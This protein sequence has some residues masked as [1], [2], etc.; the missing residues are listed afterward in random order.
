MFPCGVQLTRLY[1]MAMRP[2][3]SGATRP[4]DCAWTSNWLAWHSGQLRN[5][6]M[7]LSWQLCRS[8]ARR[9]TT[10]LSVICTVTDWLAESGLHLPL[11]SGPS[12]TQ[13]SW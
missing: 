9:R 10:H 13:D 11:N 7:S 1:C 6:H 4:N 5:G 3:N 12:F 2:L 8:H